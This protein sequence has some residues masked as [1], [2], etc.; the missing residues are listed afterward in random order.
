MAKIVFFP[1]YFCSFLRVCLNIPK[2]DVQIWEQ[3]QLQDFSSPGHVLMENGPNHENYCG[4]KGQ[5][6]SKIYCI[7]LLK[8]S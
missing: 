6:C 8:A 5:K 3:C 7:L 1:R 2:M 4:K